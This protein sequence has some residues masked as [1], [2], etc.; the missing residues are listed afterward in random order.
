M[1]YIVTPQPLEKGIEMPNQSQNTTSRV[2]SLDGGGIRGVMTAYWLAAAEDEL[3]GHIADHVDLIAGTST[4]SILAAAL[5]KRIPASEI[6]DLYRERGRDIFPATG[7][8]LW[9]RLGRVFT[10]GPS[11]PKYD[12]EGLEDS[13]KDCLGNTKMSELHEETK[14]LITTYDTVIRQPIILKSWRR[15]YSSVPL[16]EATKASSSAPT[17]FPAH[18]TGVLGSE[19][20][21]IDGGVVA[22]NPTACAI[23]EAVRLNAEDGDRSLNDF[24]VGSFGTGES[25]R[26]ISVSQAREWG[27]LEWAVPII[28]VLMDGAS[29]SASYIAGQLIPE[30]Q[31]FRFDTKLDNAFDDMDD[32]STTNIDALLRVANAYLEDGGRKRIQKF[33]GQ[34]TA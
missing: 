2:L 32:A 29:D 26:P 18:K 31:Y 9:N 28:S 7:E 30:G 1:T 14:L 8:R 11:A 22:N 3:N 12:V 27:A 20:A 6:V 5:S 24:V 16:W 10:Q 4:G 34:L 19:T 23:A 21:L 13:L 25:T 33:C 17:Y 15:E